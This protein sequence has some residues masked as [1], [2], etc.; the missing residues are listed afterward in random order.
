MFM[1]LIAI[2]VIAACGSDSDDV[3]TLREDT[4]AG[5]PTVEAADSVRDAEEAMMAL[6]ECLREQGIEAYDPVVDAD[7]NVGK[8]ELGEGDDE[9]EVW[10]AWEACEHHLEGVSFEK[11]RVDVSQ[12]VDQYVEL[13]TCLRDKGYDVGD[14]TA[15][16]LDQWMGD[17]KNAINWDDPAAVAD[18]EECSSDGTFGKGK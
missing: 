15:E 6:T 18:Y 1:A 14:P 2:L 12:Q 4:R 13:A 16:T 8:P 7:G 11:E 9:K 17:F 10:A 5:E 3:P